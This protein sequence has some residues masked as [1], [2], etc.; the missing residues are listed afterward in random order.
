[1]NLLGEEGCTEYDVCSKEDQRSSGEWTLTENS[2]WCLNV[3]LP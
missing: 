1:M 2:F 3:V